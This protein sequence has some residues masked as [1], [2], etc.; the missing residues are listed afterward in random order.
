MLSIS[1]PAG[2]DFKTRSKQYASD[3]CAVRGEW[4]V[5]TTVG[6]RP[7]GYGVIVAGVLDAGRGALD[8]IADRL[9]V[10]FGPRV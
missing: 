6:P 9:R 3:I 7:D 8:L 2:I 10:D 4:T 1:Q 5:T